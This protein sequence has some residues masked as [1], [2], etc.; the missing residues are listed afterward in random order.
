MSTYVL[1]FKLKFDRL[2]LN[3]HAKYL[4]KWSFRSNVIATRVLCLDH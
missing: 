3:Q 2:K 1:D 4:G